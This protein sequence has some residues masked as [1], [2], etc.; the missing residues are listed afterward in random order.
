MRVNLFSST[1]Q[2]GEKLYLLEYSHLKQ[3]LAV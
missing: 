2:D 1:Y 3:L